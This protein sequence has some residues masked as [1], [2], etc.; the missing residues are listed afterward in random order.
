M[1]RI[2]E[3]YE[4]KKNYVVR[5]VCHKETYDKFYRV[6]YAYKAKYPNRFRTMEDF[7]NFLLELASAG[8]I[9]FL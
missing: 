4:G 1:P 5:V 9:S 8:K 7:L 3:D 6:F 2:R